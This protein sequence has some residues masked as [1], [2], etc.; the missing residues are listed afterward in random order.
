MEQLFEAIA[1]LQDDL[2]PFRLD[3][4]EF[5]GIC[6]DVV[7]LR[8]DLMDVFP[9]TFAN[10]AGVSG[11]PAFFVNGIFIEGAQPASAFVEL[12]DAELVR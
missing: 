5:A 10:E 3:I 4:L 7:E 12:I 9:A 11:T 8:V 1:E 2:G 6:F